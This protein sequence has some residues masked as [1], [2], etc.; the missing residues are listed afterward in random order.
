MGTWA[1]T[2]F[3]KRRGLV[4]EYTRNE[5]CSINEYVTDQSSSSRRYRPE[6]HARLS[7]I[8]ARFRA[9]TL[10]AAYVK[11]Y[12]LVGRDCSLVGVGE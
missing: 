7:T 3:I 9:Y 5:L 6:C 12:S 2:T 11:V 10:M 8:R 4:L 1:E